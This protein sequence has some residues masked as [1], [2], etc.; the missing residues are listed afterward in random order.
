MMARRFCPGLCSISSAR[1]T[2]LS[3]STLAMIGHSRATPPTYLRGDRL[4]Q[5]LSSATFSDCISSCCRISRMP[6]PQAPSANEVQPSS[7]LNRGQK[8]A[9][10]KQQNPRSP[11][12]CGP[13]R[14]S[15]LRCDHQ[16]PCGAC[17]RRDTIQ[18]CE[19][20][21]SSERL[22]T[23]RESSGAAA[24]SHR[25]Q[26][27]E[28][29]TRANWDAL[30][31]RPEQSKKTPASTHTIS[32]PFPMALGPTIEQLTSL[33]PPAECC[34]YLIIQYFTFIAPMF[35]VLHE[36]SFQRRYNAFTR[37]RQT[38]DLSWLA[39]LFSI[40]SVSVQTLED[41]DPVLR[42]VREGVPSA[43]GTHNLAT[44]LRKHAMTC[45]S[46]DDFMFHFSLETLESLLLLIYGIS[47]DS[48]VHAAWTLLGML[49][50]AI[51]KGSS[52]DTYLRLGVKHG[53][54][55]EVQYVIQM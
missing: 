50:L 1:A 38:D 15:K 19:Y 11:T 35:H 23:T 49:N 21:R 20:G 34:D 45:L 31:Q 3:V 6:L 54:S 2:R 48:G 7:L 10:R 8:R 25:I 9:R 36:S 42:T 12:S 14:A 55:F 47:H 13:C 44:E 43:A 52:T 51:S 24:G 17:K 39:L 22:R 37:D 5:I 27:G 29:F 41:N 46:G 53:H 30:W 40:L 16:T 18:R 32:G 28:E 4:Q 33:I 26:E